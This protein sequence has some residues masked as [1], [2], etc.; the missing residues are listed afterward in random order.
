[1]PGELEIRRV[2]PDDWQDLRALRL[3]ALADTPIGFLE[4]LVVAAQEPDAVWQ[5]RAARGAH[6]GDAFQVMAWDGE[7]AVANCVCFLR[8]AAAW[9]AG[10]YVSP[11]YRSRGLLAELVDRCGD[12]AREQG[13][14]ACA[15]RSTRTTRGPVRPTR[16]WGSATRAS[17]PRTP[18]RRAARS[19]SWSGRSDLHLEPDAPRCVTVVAGVG[20]DRPGTQTGCTGFHAAGPGTGGQRAAALAAQARL[21]Y[22]GGLLRGAPD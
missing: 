5:G 21:G 3:E 16:G 9:L 7:C 2:T 15:S 17:A 13:R 11:A 6:G 22:C 20:R 14:G 8:D 19:S 4:T 12:W 10:V 1:M 18:S